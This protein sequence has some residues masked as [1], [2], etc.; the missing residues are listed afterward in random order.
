MNKQ[1]EIPYN[2]SALSCLVAGGMLVLLLTL[3]GLLSGCGTATSTNSSQP[4]GPTP[5]PTRSLK[6]TISEFLL[7]SPNSRSGD[8]TLGPD[9]NLWFT[10]MIPNAQNGS[11]T[12]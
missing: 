6:G 5:T 3:A 7:S 2:R 10:E 8:I 12:G 1:H 9:G 4:S 11:V